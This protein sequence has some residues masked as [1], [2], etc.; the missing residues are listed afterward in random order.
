[1]ILKRERP[2]AITQAI[3][4]KKQHYKCLYCKLLFGTGLYKDGKFMTIDLEWDHLVPYSYLLA[5]PINNWVAACQICNRLKYNK[6]FNFLYELKHWLV[7]ERS[8]RYNIQID[9]VPSISNEQDP[10]TWAEE[11]S[12]YLAKK[13]Q[14]KEDLKEV[15]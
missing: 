9:F 10:E 12:K 8:Y 1:M 2:S 14:L 4:L 13:G 15:N 7:E 6:I 5:N 3:I 11:F